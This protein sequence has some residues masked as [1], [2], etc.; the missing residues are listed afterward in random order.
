M[1]RI[2]G[3]APSPAGLLTFQNVQIELGFDTS[4][5]EFNGDKADVRA[6]LLGVR[7]MF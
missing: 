4:R 7:T 1:A 2:V 3:E 6:L 5:A